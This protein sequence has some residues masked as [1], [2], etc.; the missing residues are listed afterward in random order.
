M[1]QGWWIDRQSGRKRRFWQF[2]RW[3]ARPSPPLHVDVPQCSPSVVGQTT[4]PGIQ[5]INVGHQVVPNALIL[6]PCRCIDLS[7]EISK[8]LFE[9]FYGFPLDPSPQYDG[10]NIASP[11][12]SGPSLADRLRRTALALPLE[13]LLPF[14]GAMLEWPGSL[15]VFQINGVCALI[16]SERLLLADDMGLGKTVQV[17]AA[18]R[19]LCVQ[20]AIERVLVVMPAAVID[21]WKREI[22]RWAPE[23]RV[24]PVRGSPADRAWQCGVPMPM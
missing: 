19:V 2:W 9:E 11:N 6:D 22:H 21:Q 14:P 7:G 10:V 18:I 3:S 20:Q 17:I 12:Q 5:P 16:G 24:I 1:T 8:D 13:L 23:L 4:V 15:Y